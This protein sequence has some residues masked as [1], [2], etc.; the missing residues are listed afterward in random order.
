MGDPEVIKEYFFVFIALV[1]NVRVQ[2]SRLG[3]SECTLQW[4]Q[5]IPFVQGFVTY[6]GKAPVTKLYD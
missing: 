2:E 6:S 3:E 5:F 4:F 1:G